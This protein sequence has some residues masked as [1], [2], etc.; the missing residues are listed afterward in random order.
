MTWYPCYSSILF[1]QARCS[2]MK[3]ILFIQS[4]HYIYMKHIIQLTSS[5]DTTCKAMPESRQNVQGA[6]RF[7]GRFVPRIGSYVEFSHLGP[8]FGEASHLL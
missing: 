3:V 4:D 2:T 6:F 5:Y 7:E 1:F 8:G